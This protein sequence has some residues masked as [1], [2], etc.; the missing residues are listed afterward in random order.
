MEYY[1]VITDFYP[2]INNASDFE[3]A[4][5]PY[6]TFEEACDAIEATMDIYDNHNEDNIYQ[7][8]WLPDIRSTVGF[9]TIKD[10]GVGMDKETSK[11]IGTAFY[12]T[13]K[14]GTGLGVCFSREIVEKHNGTIEYFSKQGKGTMVKIILP[15]NKTSN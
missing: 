11:K 2:D 7:T 8:F 4:L 3:E 15:I 5:I 1:Y 12:T 6:H 10:N 9:I 13:K 14:N